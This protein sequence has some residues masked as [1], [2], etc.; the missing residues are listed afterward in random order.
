M[1]MRAILFLSV[2]LALALPVATRADETVILLSHSNSNDRDNNPTA[3]MAVTF[4]ERVEAASNNTLRVEIFPENQLGIDAKAVGLVGKG[5]IQMAISSVSG[6]APLYPLIGVMDYPFAYRRAEDAYAVLDGPFGQR[7]RRDIEAKTGL[8]ILG[9][10]DTGGLFVITNS[11]RPVRGPGDLAGLRIRTMK[12]ESHKLQVRSLGAEPVTIAWNRV[13]DALQAGMA[14]GQMN[15]IQTTRYG[16][17]HTVQKYMTLT[18][19]IYAPFLW[20]ANRDFMAGLSD[21]QRKAVFDAV[22][23]GIRASRAQAGDYSDILLSALLPSVQIHRP[24]EAELAAFRQATQ[25]PMRDFIAQ[26]YG[27]EG[28]SLLNDFLEA[29]RQAR[30]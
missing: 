25:A 16:R 26:T 18:N 23:E 30:H 15:P 22:V 6:V 4:K 10:G 5:V 19:H 8:A 29:V 14:D 2:A 12:S 28:I 24:T 13:F 11:R 3:A 21:S 9:F 7:L 27:E 1:A 20:T 17:L